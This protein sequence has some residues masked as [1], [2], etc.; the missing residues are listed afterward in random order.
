MPPIKVYWWRKANLRNFGDELSPLIVQQL[1]GRQIERAGPQECDLCAIGSILQKLLEDSRI[2]ERNEPLYVW[3]SGTI[4][5]TRFPAISCLR[6]ASVRGPLTRN[7]LRLPVD[8]PLGDPGLLADRLVPPATVKRHAWGIIPHHSQADAAA[9]RTLVERTP[10]AVL[11][12]VRS[13]DPVDLVREIASCDRIAATSL[14]GLIVADALKIPNL[15]LP[16]EDG[17]GRIS[18]KFT[19]YFLS[20]GRSTFTP[21]KLPPSHNLNEIEDEDLGYF[22]TIDDL[23]RQ[24]AAAFPAF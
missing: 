16:D 6:A 12:D 23:K 24:I 9:F 21:V 22:A 5:P 1:T 17:R 3:G 7:T 20:V 13:A 18:W 19:D 4:K 14:H 8:I 10:R 15:W 2:A 11:I